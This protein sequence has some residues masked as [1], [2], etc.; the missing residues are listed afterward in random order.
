MALDIVLKFD[1]F[2]SMDVKNRRKKSEV[3]G[4]ARVSEYEHHCSRTTYLEKD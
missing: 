4:T 2:R 3:S 1:G